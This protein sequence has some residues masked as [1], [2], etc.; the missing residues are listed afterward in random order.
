[1]KVCKHVVA[2]MFIA[3]FGL[4]GCGDDG[5]PPTMDA[6]GGLDAN[7][8]DSAMDAPTACPTPSS[9][10][11]MHSGAIAADETW[12][13]D[14]SPHIVMGSV[15]IEG[16]ATL[17]IEPCAVVRL[18]SD[19]RLSAGSSS[20]SGHLV[21]EGTA[22]A[23]ILF[24]RADATAWDY[25]MAEPMGSVRLAYVTLSGGGGDAVTYDGAS[26]VASGPADRPYVQNLFVDHVT[27]SGSAG[28][29]VLMRRY[30]AF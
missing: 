8:P 15:R 17:T 14:A 29:G 27:V 24:E 21:A 26:L 20:A 18:A 7:P 19:G 3:S 30:S 6:G 12:S 10:P 2:V 28:Y 22:S 4:A 13:A 9:G 1:M 11:S 16:G 25:L 5:T 23:P